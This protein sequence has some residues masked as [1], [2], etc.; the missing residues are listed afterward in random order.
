MRK[1]SLS[2]PTRLPDFLREQRDAELG[3]CTRIR[4]SVTG[5]GRKPRTITAKKSVPRCRSP[6]RNLDTPTNPA[7]PLYSDNPTFRRSP[8]P[9][10]RC[11]WPCQVAVV[12]DLPLLLWP[13]NSN[14]PN[15]LATADITLPLSCLLPPRYPCPPF[16]TPNVGRRRS[17]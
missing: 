1:I 9:L 10:H 13:M 17:P 4:R 8:R 16:R 12:P 5:E 7:N 15:S 3:G 11:Q 2:T 14:T 6:P